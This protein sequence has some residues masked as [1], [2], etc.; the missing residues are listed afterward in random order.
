MIG[1]GYSVVGWMV[2]WFEEHPPTP[3]DLLMIGEEEAEDYLH[4]SGLA[5]SVRAR[6]TGGTAH[7]SFWSGFRVCWERN[8]FRADGGIGGITPPPLKTG[9]LLPSSLLPSSLLLRR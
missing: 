2:V 7:S 3:W 8:P 1:M 5:L 4:H 9:P 6:Q